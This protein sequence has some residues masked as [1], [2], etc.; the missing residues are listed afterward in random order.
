MY[1]LGF[2]I[3]IVGGRL[4]ARVASKTRAGRWFYDVMNDPW[5]P[6]REHEEGSQ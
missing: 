6:A 4:V 3:A 5:R 1:Y 2:V